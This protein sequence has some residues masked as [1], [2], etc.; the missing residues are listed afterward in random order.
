MLS[1]N[2]LQGLS[3][4]VQNAGDAGATEVRFL[5][6]PDALLIAH[7]ARPVRL[8]DVLALATPWVTTKRHNSKAIGRFGIGLMTLQALS[9]ALELHSGLYDV[10]FGNLI[11]TAIEPLSVPDGFANAEDTIFRVPLVGNALDSGML[12]AWAEA[13][14]DSAL[15]FCNDVSRV[16]ICS[17][18]SSSRTL[19]LQWMEQ[20]PRQVA[21]GGAN[22]NVRRR[23]AIA[24]DGRMWDLHTAEVSPPE[25]VHRAHKAVGS[26]MPVGVALSLNGTDEGQLYAGLP[27]A[28]LAH[29]VR[30]NAQFDP[31]TNRQ[32]L[33]DTPWNAAISQL[34][35][36]LWIAAVIDM[37]ETDPSAAWRSIPLPG[38]TTRSGTGAVAQFESMLVK[39]ARETL[40]E[41][42]TIQVGD[43]RMPLTQL[44]TEVPRLTSV[45]SEK[46][47]AELA[48]LPAALPFNARDQE[49]RWSKVL[50]SWRQSGGNLAPLV[51]V[52]AALAL[53][54]RDGRSVQQTIALAAAAL[55]E[56]LDHKLAQVPCVIDR[57]GS[58]ERPPDRTDPWMFVTI[59]LPFAQ[60]LGVARVLHEAY[61]SDESDT[62]KVMSWLQSLGAINNSND[63]TGVLHKLAAAGQAG[64]RIE[65]PLIDSQLQAIRDAFE[66]LNQTDREKLGLGVG[67]AIMIDG[68]RFDK[69]AKRIPLHASPAQMYLP[70]NIDKE[71]ESFAVA[72]GNTPGLMWVDPRYATVLRSPAGRAGLGAQRFLHLLGAETAPRLSPHPELK[73]RY[74][75]ELRCG[76]ARQCVE[77]PLARARALHNIGAT[78]TLEDQHCLDLIAVLTD[79]SRDKNTTQRQQRASALLATI[80][81]AWDR[82]SESAEVTAAGDNRGWLPCGT[83]KAFWIWQAESIPWLDDSASQPTAPTALRLRTPGT[84]AVYGPDAQGYLH[85]DLHRSRH[86]VL[87]LFGVS[88]DPST[89]DLVEHLQALRG[90]GAGDA[91]MMRGETSVI[92][93]ALADRLASRT[94]V[95]GDLSIGSLRQAFGNGEGLILTNLGWRQPSQ[96]LGGA[97]VFGNHRA[98]TPSVPSTARLWSELRVR[99]PGVADCIDVLV[100]IAKESRH[101]DISQQTIVLETL[102]YL[103]VELPRTDQLSVPLRRKLAKLPLWTG[104]RWV[105]T[106]PVYAVG[107]SILANGLRSQVAIWHPGGDL[108]QFKSLLSPLRLT[109]LSVESANVAHGT[110]VEVDEEATNLL[111]AAVLLLREDFA[112]N[113]PET[114]KLLRIPWEQLS[115]FEFSW[116]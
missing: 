16:T 85:E 45:L 39:H 9:D 114:G 69:E 26:T 108:T 46:E 62:Q 71:P 55:D 72:A 109:E 18:S 11:V 106:R 76:L 17:S 54:G 101:P 4:I 105:R 21:I 30:V 84:V 8:R 19:A 44:A 110:A 60:E 95:P 100:E 27:V 36:D 1:G 15:L 87:A 103:A 52:K 34:V 73:H 63:V 41:L 68:Y 107:D 53:F 88:G 112:R 70:R 90:S 42:V 5:L 74:V 31:L 86:E 89:S 29:A 32:D 48:G 12:A 81:R 91:A 2:R 35:A 64:R 49:G 113:D 77:N 111:R 66:V 40:P 37:F 43:S 93:Q 50:N 57:D 94:Q 6:Q 28:S 96:T 97:P 58:A 61:S 75:N 22:T 59:E 104:D 83:I 79:I 47:I 38:P 7:N 80:G 24:P 3:E 99:A 56:R 20:T 115:R 14:D 116:N 10:R 65:Q 51:S 23:R 67:R 78:Y 98:F 33:A 82:F 25:G 92:Y 13:W 102:R